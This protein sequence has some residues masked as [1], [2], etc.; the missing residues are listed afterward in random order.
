MKKIATLIALG[1]LTACGTAPGPSPSSGTVNSPVIP[2]TPA[3]SLIPGEACQAQLRAAIGDRTADF[4][5]GRGGYAS[6]DE[7]IRGI[8]VVCGD[9]ILTTQ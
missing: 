2:A 7:A 9:R 5:M 8:R 1:L 4:V 6:Y 3:P